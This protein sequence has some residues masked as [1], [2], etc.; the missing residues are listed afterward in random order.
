[1][2]KRES[3][4]VLS[5]VSALAVCAVAASS[6]SALQA[7]AY[8]C[9]PT[10]TTLEFSKAHC[11]SADKP[12]SAFG[13]TLITETTT[14]EG[15]NANTASETKA[16]TPS[17]LEGTLA[18]FETAI[19][20][21]GLGATGSLTNEATFVKGTGV[22]N[23]T[24]CS[25]QKPSGI[26]CVVKGNAV[27]TEEL[28]ATTGAQVLTNLKFEPVGTKF[29]GITIEGCS[30]SELN[31]TFPV[32]G[33]LI[34]KTNGATITTTHAGITGQGTLIFGGNFAGL[35]GA[36]TISMSGGGNAIGLT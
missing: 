2:R 33:S 25:V 1:M 22:I 5:I 34:A 21:T 8:T 11:T 32:T 10:A 12:G 24:G 14:I 19:E 4:I 3:I 9:S 29:A 23:Y 20:C 35:E 17:R 18:G 31:H 30:T 16:K 6:A 13:H 26:G 36:L 28:K 27:S 15:T 7:R